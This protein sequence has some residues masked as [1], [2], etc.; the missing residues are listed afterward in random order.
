ML[1][2]SSLTC[3]EIPIPKSIRDLV[4]APPVFLPTSGDHESLELLKKLGE[5][6]GRPTAEIAQTLNLAAGLS[7]IVIILQR[8]NRTHRFNVSFEDFVKSCATLLAVDELIRFASK[9]ARSIHTVTILDAFSYQPDKNAEKRDK[10]CHEVL[11]HILRLKKPKVV[12]R[13]HQDEYC[14]EWLKR[15]EL[16]GEDYQLEREEIALVEEHTTVILQSF[17]PSCA[18]NNANCRPEYRALLIYHFVAAFSELRSECILPETAERVR[19]LCLIKGERKSHDIPVYEPWQAARSI[20]EILETTYEGPSKGYFVRIVD[21]TMS[22]HRSTQIKAFDALY[23]SLRQLFGS[24]KTFGG[25]LAIAKIVLFLWEQHFQRDP[26]YDQIT[27]WLILRGNEEND[28]FPCDNEIPSD[29]R[30]L[31]DQLSCLQISTPRTISDAR[32]ME[33]EVVPLLVQAAATLIRGENLAEDLHTHIIKSF[34]KHNGLVR[35]YLRESSMC[36][37]NHAMRVRTL[38]IR[39]ETALSAIRVQSHILGPDILRDAIRCLKDLA[40]L[41]DAEWQR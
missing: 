23:G 19:K 27:A 38:L 39:C 5:E 22:E 25:G 30:T 31:E 28:W 21:Y 24:R 35:R 29:R 37:I 32:L 18:V 33:D 40:S 20:S 7:D 36:D 10:R 1:P 14:G 17:H 41:L 9:G 3:L 16:P 26:L 15:I 13:C 8:P 6:F 12:L 11:A 2:H 4:T 34:N